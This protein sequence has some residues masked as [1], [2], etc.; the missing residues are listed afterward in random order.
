MLAA[1][2][3]SMWH[4]PLNPRDVNFDQR[5]SASDLLVVVNEL[6]QFGSHEL[7]TDGVAPLAAVPGHMNYVD[8][9]GDNR[10]SSSDVLMIVNELV[11]TDLMLVSTYPTDLD[12]N[13]ITTIPV[14][15][16]F[17]L[18]TEVQDIRDPAP[19]IPGVFAA[20]A[21]IS[22]N[23]NLT[24]I[25]TGQTA[26]FV[27]PGSV[28]DTF[29]DLAHET[30]LQ[31]GRVIG[32]G[33]HGSLTSPGNAPQFLFSVVLT[34]EQAGTQTFTPIYDT[35]N[36]DHE[37][38]LFLLNGNRPP[39]EVQFVGSML[40][41]TDVPA[42]T[43][44]NVSQSETNADSTFNFTVNLSEPADAEVTVAYATSDVT[45]T[46]D[47]D[48][49]PT[50][51]TLTFAVG[52]TVAVIPVTVKGDTTVEPNESFNVILSN[53]SP[54]A[55]IATALGVGTIQND[56]VLAGLTI[57]GDTV[58]NVTSDTTT[59]NFTVT[60]SQ[61]ITSD[62]TVQYT[63]SDLTAIAG[64]D[65]EAT[66]GTLTFTPGGNLSQS[67]PVTIIGDPNADGVDTFLVSLSNPSANATITT[68][69]ATITINP[70]VSAPSVLVSNVSHPEGNAGQ[71]PYVFTVSLSTASGQ[72]VLVSYTTV[73]GTAT[74]AG[75][76]YVPTSGTLTFSAGVTSRE[77]T[78]QAV[79]DTVAEASETFLLHVEAVENA[80]GSADGT[81]TIVDD[82]GAPTVVISD[83]T[84]S[85]GST[86]TEAVFTVTL[87]GALTQAVSVGFATSDD[88]AKAGEDYLTA[89]G[90]LTFTPG[91]LATQEI[92]V[93]ILGVAAP[94]AD[95]LFFVN[96]SSPSGVII[97]DDLGVGT[98]VS[99][100][101]S[102]NSEVVLVEGN[103]GSQTAVFTVSLSMPF[104]HPVTVA[105]STSDGT[106]TSAGSD[107][108]PA[109]GTLTFESGVQSQTI[110]VTVFGDTVQE[111]NENFFVNLSN[112]SGAP[113]F[114][115]VSKGTILNDDGSQVAY[116]LELTDLS[117]T[118]LAVNKTLAVD[119]EFYLYVYVRDVQAEPTGLL[120]AYI[121]VTYQPNLVEPV[122]SPEFGPNLNSVPTW[123]IV[124]G[125]LN[126][127][128]ALDETP[129]IPPVDPSAEELLYRIKFKAT[130]FGLLDFTGSVNE[131][132]LDPGHETLLY[133]SPNAEPVPS[134]QMTVE[135]RSINVGS[136]VFTISDTQAA[137]NNSMVFTVKRF[138][139][140]QQTATVVYTTVDNGSATAGDDYTPTSGTLTFVPGE[141]DTQ[142]VTV[143]L[144]D[145]TINE[146]NETFQLVLSDPQ[147]AMLSGVKA[148]TGT[149]QD[150]DSEPSVSVSGGNAF[151]GSGVEFVVS[152]SSVSGK[153]V[154]VAYATTGVGTA[155]S[156]LDYSPA[157]G[158]VTFAPGV[159]QQTVTV[160]TLTDILIESNESFQ[161][162]LSNPVNA[163]LGTAQ[164]LGIIKDVP[165][166][167]ILGYVYVD[168]NNNGLK[169]QGDDG[170][171]GVIVTATRD[172][173]GV[174]VS[175][176]TGADGSYSFLG[177]T[178]GTY[179]L[180]ETQPGFYSDGRDAR[181]G[182]DSPFNDKFAGIVLASSDSQA[183]Y[184]FGELGIRSD[185]VSAFIN[186]RALFASAVVGGVFGPEMNTEGTILNLRTGD[187][188]VSFDGGWSGIRQI[189][190]L[191]DSSQGTVNMKLYNNSL[192]EIASSL[193]GSAGSSL[194]Y[195][196]Q[197]G[198]TYFLRISGT[199]ANVTL[200]ISSP[201][202][203]TALVL[204]GQ[205]ASTAGGAA[206][207]SGGS[208]DPSVPTVGG[209]FGS[210]A[211]QAMVAPE[212]EPLVAADS[213]D[214]FDESEDWLLESLL[215]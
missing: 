128:G 95:K 31:Q 88:S 191:F 87:T 192:Q 185:F 144:I 92:H 130:D 53:P 158:T 113:I 157:A 77:V 175:T 19:Q 100:G 13:P 10:V 118:P 7:S 152:L 23:S 11:D 186:R 117:G 143:Q 150:N 96:L 81:G 79:G 48:Y 25:D 45:A 141:S 133:F 98:I 211:P 197:L 196:G 178:P 163:S 40:Q 72:D 21:D 43:I 149:I 42:L 127:F 199:N 116:R 102:I 146:A 177:L 68:G 54:N 67:V 119:E 91:G 188:W 123:N 155:T 29:W 181:F 66:S 176:Q 153:T 3:A 49:V 14:G 160:T 2:V 57:A 36:P 58:N 76:D 73:D 59:A 27:P 207:T 171:A 103:T 80:V 56:D 142:T 33:S 75:N 17:L 166:A 170:I 183:G 151:E 205:N 201:V 162:A 182:I 37:Y 6:L 148:G 139:P 34:A 94:S 214:A 70:A 120:E 64:L 1:D 50:S 190:A 156:G 173:D 194:L 212:S 184:N 167:G 147:N 63:T 180:T 174:S 78:V 195:N 204:P 39:E 61:D 189:D 16:Q 69:Q 5:V 44:G 32:F 126:D 213:D 129:V 169:D 85:A 47:N 41:I 28:G 60:L 83:A 137:E 55:T 99:Q 26:E 30:T 208:S 51:G 154:T 121:D 132:D 74:E 122:G 125:R 165:P 159:T 168:M 138:L 134:S 20:A 101:I 140:S 200:Q 206:A 136:N 84:V 86:L 8:V 112:A 203:P 89:T 105:Y 106:A 110:S 114:T 179:T 187:I 135:G 65:Y 52:Q 109:S 145:D 210:A 209:R 62:V 124:P 164:T 90:N 172:S 9:N 104:E 161:L 35:T 215:S 24:S 22:F 115:G 46:A 193:P 202:L 93:T 82:D 71:T 198:H 12:G 18:V 131:S 15:G 38:L 108:L 4:N 97:S 107:Y 111:A